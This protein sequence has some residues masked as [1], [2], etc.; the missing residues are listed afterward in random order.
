MIDCD[1]HRKAIRF[2]DVCPS[3]V[4]ITRRSLYGDVIHVVVL[5]ILYLFAN[6]EDYERT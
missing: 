2:Y 6:I 4:A 1:I 5:H 3:S